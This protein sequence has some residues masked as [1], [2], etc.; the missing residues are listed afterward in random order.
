MTVSPETAPGSTAARARVVIC[1]ATFRRPDGLRTL[2]ESLDALEFRGDAPEI[3]LVIVDNDA[4]SP[5][6]RV[7]GPLGALIRWPLSYVVEPQRGIVSARN[8]ALSEA[9]HADDFIAFLDDDERVAPG[10]LEALLETQA[11]TGAAAVVG[12]VIPDFQAQPADW[13]AEGGYFHHGPF[14]EGAPM[15]F[16][17]TSN[18]L[19]VR[20]EIERLGLRFD[21]RFNHTG[22]EDQEF[23]D[24]LIESGGRI[25]ASAAADVIESVPVQRMTLRWL[26]R[27]QYRMGNTITHVDILRRRR[28]WL[29]AM[30]GAAFV[31]IGAG[32]ALLG[33]ASGLGRRNRGLISAARGLGMLTAF[34]GGKYNEYSDAAMSK[35][36]ASS[37]P[38]A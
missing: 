32:N 38:A 13:I 12:G 7:L 30:K 14:E 36:R 10:W 4:S 31:L 18:V 27:R 6:E 24:R 9:G 21:A 17:S 25:V 34:F 26:L 11:R 5:V 15:A 37:R 28:L 23:F 8:R 16:A 1:V 29:R 22:G 33:V 3:R 2:L 19:M 35:D 20:S